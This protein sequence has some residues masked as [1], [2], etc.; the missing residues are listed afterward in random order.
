MNRPVIH[1]RGSESEYRSGYLIKVEKDA[2]FV[3]VEMG[4]GEIKVVKT[5]RIIRIEGGSHDKN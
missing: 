5:D 3:E 2:G 1:F 4:D